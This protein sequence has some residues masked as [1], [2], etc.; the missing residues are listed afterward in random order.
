VGGTRD[1]LNRHVREAGFKRPGLDGHADEHL[2]LGLTADV[3]QVSTLQTS[4]ID[5]LQRITA[6][7]SNT[8]TVVENLPG[9]IQWAA[10]TPQVNEGA[11]AVDNYVDVSVFRSAGTFGVVDA[12]LAI[13]TTATL[14]TEYTLQIG[15]DVSSL[16]PFTS[17][18]RVTFLDGQVS[19]IIRVTCIGDSIAADVDI[20]MTLSG[21]RANGSVLASV[22]GINTV[23]VVSLLE[24]NGGTPILV[25][26]ASFTV[27]NSTNTLTAAITL[28]ATNAASQII[29]TDATVTASDPRW[30]AYDAT[31]PSVQQPAYDA[32][33]TWY[34]HFK[35]STGDIVSVSA[36]ATASDTAPPSLPTGLAQSGATSSSITAVC[37]VSTDNEGSAI[38]YRFYKDAVLDG[39]SATPAYTFTGITAAATHSI[40]ADVVDAFGNAS[41]QTAGVNMTASAA[42]A[43]IFT[44]D[45]TANAGVGPYNLDSMTQVS[46]N[47]SSYHTEALVA[48]SNAL[49]MGSTHKSTF[50]DYC[51]DSYFGFDVSIPWSAAAI[52]W[53][54]AMRYGDD[55]NAYTW[56]NPETP[57]NGACGDLTNRPHELKFPDIGGGQGFVGNARIIGKVRQSGLGDTGR[58]RVYTNDGTDHNLDDSTFGMGAS[59]ILESNVPYVIQF[60]CIDNLDGTQT[61]KIWRHLYGGAP[62]E[63]A[64][65]D[66][67]RTGSNYFDSTLWSAPPSGGPGLY[68]GHGYRNH[69][70]VASPVQS[71]YIGADGVGPQ[72]SDSFIL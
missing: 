20:T 11:A 25:T 23:S 56:S 19:K 48:D 18:N 15:V 63:E 57:T 54:C 16:V 39:T 34:A 33:T 64:T 58:Y 53:K 45:Y 29:T 1:A 46:T 71:L 68:F 66:Y 41:A 42:S 44:G 7:E 24:N 72:F 21:H 26:G 10:T 47:D 12:I 51:L 36:A 28:A 61:V 60:A 32:L 70:S 14:T 6:L 69:N 30:S 62:S 55:G 37:N 31:I 17:G 4:L 13:T 50:L 5:A 27:A 49:S 40:T 59:G 3:A 8:G 67:E 43:V 38:T 52:Y 65:P 9:Q 22:E 2:E 35:S